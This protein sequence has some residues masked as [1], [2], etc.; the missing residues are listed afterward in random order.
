M[1]DTIEQGKNELASI[2]NELFGSYVGNNNPQD[3]TPKGD[4][5]K[6]DTPKNYAVDDNGLT[7]GTMT[8]G[9]RDNYSITSPLTTEEVKAGN[10]DAESQYK[11]I[12]GDVG[13]KENEQDIVDTTRGRSS[14]VQ[15]EFTP[16]QAKYVNPWQ[17]NNFAMNS[18]YGNLN[19]KRYANTLNLSRM[20]DALNNQRHWIGAK[21]GRRTNSSF[22]TNDYQEG[23]SEHWEPINTQ[24]IRQVRANERLD[25]AQRQ[26]EIGLQSAINRYG[27]DLQKYMD[28]MSNR[29]IEATGNDNISFKRAMQDA[30]LDINYRNPSQLSQT[31]RTQIFSQYLQK[32]LDAKVVQ[33][34]YNIWLK[35]PMFGSYWSDAMGKGQMPSYKDQMYQEIVRQ[36]KESGKSA[37]ESLQ[38][39]A[40]LESMLTMNAIYQ[41]GNTFTR[42][43]GGGLFNSRGS[44]SGF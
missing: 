14:Q 44:Y 28:E 5:P 15:R 6:G 33:Q 1:A 19:N 31:Q 16:E 9:S 20:A 8:F 10:T 32:E 27:F 35:N 12:K 22:G 11:N 29:V 43:I 4:T 24:E 18:R 2:M 25:E 23:H 40:A 42:G 30:M 39:L 36:A 37:Q 3:N 13:S 7:N 21:V 34:A 38:V 26:Q 41:Y 17:Q